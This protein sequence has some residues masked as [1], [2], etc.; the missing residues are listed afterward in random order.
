MSEDEAVD[1]Y[2]VKVVAIIL[3]VLLVGLPGVCYLITLFY[4]YMYKLAEQG[5]WDVDEPWEEGDF[6]DD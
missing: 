4:K 5:K 1:T 3:L 2:E 6:D